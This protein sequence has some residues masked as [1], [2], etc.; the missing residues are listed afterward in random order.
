MST[1]DEC[2][3]GGI[4]STDKTYQ[5]NASDTELESTVSETEDEHTLLNA[6]EEYNDHVVKVLESRFLTAF[7]DHLD[8]AAIVIPR[9]YH[10]SARPSDGD[11][12]FTSTPTGSNGKGKSSDSRSSQKQ[13]S[14]SSGPPGQGNQKSGSHQR[15]RV[16]D[17]DDH[18]DQPR[19]QGF[20]PMKPTLDHASESFACHFHK[21]DPLE[22]NASNRETKRYR[23]CMDPVIPEL[24]RIKYANLNP[25]FRGISC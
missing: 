8:L 5:G 10:S 2:G 3:G 1:R 13:S 14:S 11:D 22:F 9:I 23:N 18:G 6:D 19:K 16:R 4:F 20:K 25:E 21:F 15:K 17:S 7:K 12:Q 24:R